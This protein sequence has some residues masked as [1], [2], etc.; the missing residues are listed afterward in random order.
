M[1]EPLVERTKIWGR[2]DGGA[3]VKTSGIALGK[4]VF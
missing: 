1:D 4:R 2:L 3:E